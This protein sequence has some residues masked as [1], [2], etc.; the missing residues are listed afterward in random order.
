[1]DK[2]YKLLKYRMAIH[3]F[4]SYSLKNAFTKLVIVFAILLIFPINFVRYED[5]NVTRMRN[6]FLNLIFLFRTLVLEHPI[7]NKVVHDRSLD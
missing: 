3:L 4:E 1:M 6:R 2:V 7:A 5:K